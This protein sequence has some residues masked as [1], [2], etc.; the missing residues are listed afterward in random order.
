MVCFTVRYC[1]LVDQFV[2]LLRKHYSSPDSGTKISIAYRSLTTDIIT[3]YCFANSFNTLVDPN[4]SHPVVQQT[5][6]GIKRMWIQVY[7][8]FIVDVIRSLPEKFVLWL[9]PYFA[10]FVD[11]KARFEQQIDSI[12]GDPD[13]LSTTEHETIYHNLL[14]PKDP[15]LRPSRTSLVHEAFLLVSAG[16]DTVGH[17]CTVGTYFALQDHSISGRLA[18]ELRKAWADEDIPMS[19][20]ALE[21]LP[22]LTAFAKEALRMSIGIIH[23]LPRIVGDETPHI[24]GSKIP[25][26]TTVG[27]SQYFMHMNPEVFSDPY[28][29]NPDRWLVED[30]DEM[31]LHFVPFSKGP[32]QWYA[33]T[34]LDNENVDQKVFSLG[35]NLAWCELYLILGNV[36]RRLDLCLV[37]ENEEVDLKLGKVPD[38]FVPVWEKSEYEAF[39]LAVELNTSTVAKN[40]SEALQAP[41]AVRWQAYSRGPI[42]RTFGMHK[43]FYLVDNHVA[44]LMRFTPE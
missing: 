5:R 39:S 2:G 23:P 4:F 28:T 29:F 38:Y 3:D 8:P 32:R 41:Q 16:S 20:T 27:M 13:T 24:G 10:S 21:K 40:S 34:D 12:I 44:D 22:Y 19:F 42:L 33:N 1:K 18:E 30:T 11:V 36:F 31:M 17:A 7:F 6:D 9:V 43:S 26:G 35:L 14:A 25:A 15:Q 37:G